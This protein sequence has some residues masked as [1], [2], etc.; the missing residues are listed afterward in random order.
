MMC[1]SLTWPPG[2]RHRF[3]NIRAGDRSGHV[4]MNRSSGNMIIIPPFFWK[5][6]FS[7]PALIVLAVGPAIADCA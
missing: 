7:S 4:G 3:A 5:S 6:R 1:K 2:A